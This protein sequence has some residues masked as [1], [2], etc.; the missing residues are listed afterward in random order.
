MHE[1]MD[2]L[3]RETGDE[4]EARS[5]AVEQIVLSMDDK[6]TAPVARDA[7]LRCVGVSV[8]KMKRVKQCTKFCEFIEFI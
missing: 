2:R 8:I 5:A 6:S 1:S 7:E 3:H 4:E